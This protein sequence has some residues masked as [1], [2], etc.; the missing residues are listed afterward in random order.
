MSVHLSDGGNVHLI[1]VYVLGTNLGTC[2]KTGGG[3]W[4]LQP[5]PLL[6]PRMVFLPAPCKTWAA[7][8]SPVGTGHAGREAAG[9]RGAFNGGSA[10]ACAAGGRSRGRGSGP[11]AGPGRAWRSGGSGPGCRAAGPAP[12]RGGPQVRRAHSRPSLPFL[13]D[14][15]DCS[16]AGLGATGRAAGRGAGLRL[17]FPTALRG[18]V[19]PA[20]IGN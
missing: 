14:G 10:P 5:R 13:P 7:L 3:F 4:C 12:R 11:W 9:A 16:A 8:S 1:A 2:Q 15:R 18:P 6:V 17:H 20:P 19:P